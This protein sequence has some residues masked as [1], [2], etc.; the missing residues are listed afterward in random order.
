MNKRQG[1]QAKVLKVSRVG[2]ISAV[3]GSIAFATG[4]QAEKGGSK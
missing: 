3:I 2:I 1:L 4:F